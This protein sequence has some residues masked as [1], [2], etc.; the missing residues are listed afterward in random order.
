MSKHE[1]WSDRE[2]Y[3]AVI[4]SVD[5]QSGQGFA[6]TLLP[7]TAFVPG[8]LSGSTCWV[9]TALDPP[10]RGEA[11]VCW[12]QEGLGGWFRGMARLDGTILAYTS[13]E[14]LL[15]K[16]RLAAEDVKRRRQQRWIERREQIEQQI[17]ELPEPLQ[18]RIATLRANKAGRD[19][20][21]EWLEYEVFIMSQ[22]AVLADA[23]ETVEQIKS[24]SELS[25]DEQYARVPGLSREH[26][27]YSFSTTVATAR[28][29]LEEP[30]ALIPVAGE[31]QER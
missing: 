18:Q 17:T 19:D 16:H 12:G 28:I 9:D 10:A 24:F 22:A 14:D 30:D 29:L 25:V 23:L 11:V 8:A 31:G 21:S 20:E 2:R 1:A 27:G 4:A 26:S 7:A 3:F 5:E 13:M 15:E 6:A